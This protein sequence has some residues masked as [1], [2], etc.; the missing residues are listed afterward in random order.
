MAGKPAVATRVVDSMTENLRPTR[1]EATDVA[2]AILDGSNAILIGAE[3]LRGLYP[4]ETISTAPLLSQFFL[5]S[6]L[7]NQPQ[8]FPQLSPS[9]RILS[10]PTPLT[11]QP[12]ILFLKTIT[13]APSPSF[14]FLSRFPLLPSPFPTTTVVLVCKFREQNDESID[15]TFKG[16]AWQFNKVFFELVQGGHGHLVM[17]KKKVC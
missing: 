9:S 12:L 8:S 6:H 11:R 10:S 5:P 7:T 14:L 16:V 15:L 2:N 13:G 3:T 1:A 4:M 17:V